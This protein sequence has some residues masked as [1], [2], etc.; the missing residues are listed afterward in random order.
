MSFDALL[1][2]AIP[3]FNRA[4]YLELCLERFVVEIRSLDANLQEKIIISVRDNNSDDMTCAV[5]ARYMERHSAFISYHKN[6]KN[7][8]GDLNIAEC[9]KS[10]ETPYVWIFGD[11]DVVLPGSLDVIL[12]ALRKNKLDILYV[13]GYG[14]FDDYRAEPRFGRTKRGLLLLNRRSF[15]KH[16]HVMLTFI[17]AL[18]VRTN[19][20]R[21][22]DLEVVSG[23]RLIQLSWVLALI[24]DGRN[25]GVLRNRV[26]AAKAGNSGG[27]GAVDVF[28]RQLKKISTQI[29]YDN[30]RFAEVICNGALVNWF[31][32]YAMDT[33]LGPT[34]Y[35]D[36]AVVSD[37]EQF[38]HGNWRYWVLVAPLFYLPLNIARAHFLGVRLLRKTFGKVML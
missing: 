22:T 34:T 28:G 33:R 2:I 24:R 17:T 6:S 35:I 26:F 5:V 21:P 11:D 29:F 9:Y 10:A 16:T 27:Y 20:P 15:V 14:F 32:N 31:A 36:D 3:T 25:F 18:I 8:G 1:T 19:A 13:H 30:P 37:L 38:F 12:R 7:I 4:S 23:T